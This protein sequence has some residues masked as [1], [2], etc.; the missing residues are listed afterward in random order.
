MLL[1]CFFVQVSAQVKAGDVI[2]GQVWDS[3]EP[4]MMC[5][6]VEVDNNKRI[7]AHGVTDINGN[8]SFAIK[9]PKNKIRISYI[10]CET[11]E[12][13]ITKRAFGKIVLKSKT[14]LKEVTVKAE[15]KSQS[16]GLAIP[17]TQIS[18][19][20]QT[21]DMKEFEGLAMTSVDEA[22]QGRVAGLDIT[23]NSG[24]LG[25]GTSIR[26]RG[27]STIHG[28]QNPLIVVN[29][30]PI[31]APADFDY[32]NANNERFAE[33]LQVNPDDIETI[34]VLKDAAA[35]AIWGSKGSNGVI[36]IKTKR[37]A[38]GKTRVS[39][40]YRLTGN[41]IYKRYKLLNG[42]DYTMYMK[43]AYFNPKQ[44][45]SFSN[46]SDDVNFIPEIAYSKT[47]GERNMFD[48][49]TDWVDAVTQFGMLHSHTINLTGGGEKANFRISAGYD[50][51]SNYIIKQGMDRLTT[52]VALDYFVSK[53]IQVN[54][55][56][57][58][59]YTDRDLHNTGS[60]IGTAQKKM[61][62]L[63]IYREDAY[64]N[65]LD[66]F[67]VLNRNISK[68][69]GSE[70]NCQGGGVRVGSRTLNY[71]EDQYNMV[72]PVAMAYNSQE[73]TKQLIL[74]P[75]FI[76]KYD[77]LGVEEGQH[78]LRYE[79]QIRFNIQN[80]E[81]SR[82]I[83]G[84]LW[85]QNMFSSPQQPIGDFQG[86]NYSTS[87]SSK[88]T[89][90]STRHTLTF[91]PALPQDHNLMVMA[92]Y[93]YAQN[94]G[95]SQN[96]GKVLLPTAN[97]I[98]SPLS[99]G[100]IKD[101]GSG[102]S[103]GKSQNVT[104]QAH[105]SYKD[106]RYSLTGVLRGDCTTAFGPERPWGFFPA[107]SGR[108]N[109]TREPFMEKVKWLSMLSV[110][111][112]WGFSGSAPGGD[113]WR[114]KY[115]SGPGYM[116]QSSVVPVN[117]RLGGLRFEKKQSYQIGFD[118]GFL[119]DKI[120]GNVDIYT[121]KVT[122]LLQQNYNIPSS[123]GYPTLSWYNDGSMRNEGWEFNLN[124]NSVVESADKK[125]K[126]DVNVS[127]AN[128]RN[129]V[130]S[131]DP[132]CLENLNQDFNYSN[133]QYLS[134][135]QLN[136]PLNSIYGFRYKGVYAYSEYSEDEKP[137]ISGPNAPVV[138]NADGQPIFDSMG[139]PKM[140][141]FNYKDGS[142]DYYFVGGDAIYE[143]VNHDG[144]INELDIV[145]L[146]SSLPKITGGFGTRFTYGQWQLN[147]QF[148][149]RAGFKVINTARM[150]LEN[151][152]NNNNQSLAVNWRWHNEGDEALL[153]RA[154]TT[155]TNFNTYNYLGSDRFVEDA[156]FVRLN[157][158][159]LSYML[160]KSTLTKIGLSQLRFNLTVNNAF[161]L[162]KYS[163]LDP[164]HGA[165]GY[166]PAY[167]GDTNPRSRSF[168]FG[169]SVSF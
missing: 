161:C 100:L 169:V 6:V 150:D 109:I 42:D 22:L 147:L 140:M 148:N 1:A 29:G 160:P 98:T 121:S 82:F 74:R 144:T 113:L 49:N 143:D 27:V 18:T 166:S 21:I 26:L 40:N 125:F 62:N 96:L 111:P 55:N 39:Y 134:R 128:N 5:N 36:E 38:K 156:S 168:T 124:G 149:F 86:Y 68:A 15:R 110:R 47:W 69:D 73:K 10:G 24:D 132:T 99:G 34:T 78:R 108:W 33:L 77:I 17:M 31:D 25:A 118:F 23:L 11:I 8:F 93:D 3:L 167:D 130:L 103:H 60:A 70:Y 16:T 83:P 117:I 153:P 101:F 112:S 104:F 89:S 7:V 139:A 119:K 152:S 95:S 4:L 30:N 28:N 92:R 122:D 116:G 90:M 71:L 44:D 162:T 131:M 76:F 115:A 80:D 106:G 107:L 2:S 123:S 135:V 56:F 66:E 59:I 35:Q 84:N 85:S 51:Q 63:S 164:E 32:N 138:R 120:T 105:Y 64:G 75:E 145:Y 13:P 81:N 48:D 151:M 41:W 19:A 141:S 12:L 158:A 97:G 50:T 43:E 126:M 165:G 94:N 91:T 14:T 67:Y 54:T 163:G 72:N 57:D 88:G 129:R 37:G 155:R 52:N 146:G 137:G 65:D 159:M 154:A 87:G 58:F 102:A 45:E 114:S 127:F 61:P 142:A 9:S 133:G 157:Y 136:N 79:G 20:S 53:R 46:S